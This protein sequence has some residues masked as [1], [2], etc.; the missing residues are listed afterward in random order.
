MFGTDASSRL[1]LKLRRLKG[2]Y[3]LGTPPVAVRTHLPWYLRA[4]AV[5]ILSAA[6]LALAGWIYSAGL[7]FAGFNQN[8]ADQEIV[9]MRGRIEQLTVEL[10]AARKLG[11]ASESRLR[12]ESTSQESLA[13]QIKTLE[14][15]NARLQADLNLFE[16]LAGGP[17]GT[18][19]AAISR[20]Q[21][22]KIGSNGEHRYRLFLSHAGDKKVK[23][24]V[25]SIQLIATVSRGK[26]TAMMQFPE[27]G[28]GAT[29]QY[30]VSF[31]HFRRMEGTFKLVAD[32][33]LMRVE[34]RL[35]QNGVV[36][37]SQNVTL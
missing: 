3:G 31:R 37:A 36:K 33:R 11:N 24:F 25:G 2:R 13:S 9:E 4:T 32:M 10:D 23:E 17:T 8:S 35:V 18:V 12:I 21:V 1:A 26:E 14:E 22:E 19:G 29:G 27:L 28:D 34:V 20:F 15:E 16:S 7:R 30:Q 5:I 6:S